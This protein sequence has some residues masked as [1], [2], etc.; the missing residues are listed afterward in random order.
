[1]QLDHSFT[2]PADI[3]T[4]WAALM[5]PERVAPCMPGATLTEY[6]GTTFAGTVKVKLGPISLVYKGSGEF[7]E[8]DE[9]THRA[10]IKAAG[11]DSRGNGTAAATIAVTLTQH[12]ESTTGRVVTDLAITGKPAQFGR[13]MIAEVGGK[14]LETFAT[15]LAAKLAAPATDTAAAEPPAADLVTAAAAAAP[16]PKAPKASTKAGQATPASQN[17]SRPIPDSTLAEPTRAPADA[18]RKSASAEPARESAPATS[19]SG[20]AE[21]EAAEFRPAEPG[22]VE[23]KVAESRPAEPE[24]DRSQRQ[25]HAVPESTAPIDLLEYAG[26]S[27]R[28]RLL[29]LVVALVIAVVVILRRKR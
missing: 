3:D 28:K 24:S 1:M 25:L 11:K 12:G 4:V 9:D 19:A 10:T 6:E 26:P 15:C 16:K 27:I 17:A 21:S 7:I 29:P 5:D 20:P 13:G 2:V 23:S 18:A 22:P 14:I 8:T